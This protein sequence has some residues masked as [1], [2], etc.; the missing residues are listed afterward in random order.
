MKA[1]TDPK[2][3]AFLINL[4]LILELLDVLRFHFTFALRQLKTFKFGIVILPLTSDM[5]I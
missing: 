5:F 1:D 4:I 2:K 3:T